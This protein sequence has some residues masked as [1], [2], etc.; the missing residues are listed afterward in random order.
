MST[1]SILAT[2]EY[3]TSRAEKQIKEIC[4]FLTR[5]RCFPFSSVTQRNGEN[6]VNA[7]VQIEP[8]EWSGRHVKAASPIPVGCGNNPVLCW[9]L[10]S[11]F[12]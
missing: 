2:R 6:T 1:S 7:A 11:L 5:Q 3:E 8:E 12:K 9:L 4:G 10:Y